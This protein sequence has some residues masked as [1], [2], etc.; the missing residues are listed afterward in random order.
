[1]VFFLRYRSTNNVHLPFRVHAVVDEH[2][3]VVNYKVSVR[4]LFDSKIY[5]QSVVIRIPTPP[6]TSSTMIHVTSGK[7]K[8]VGSENAIVWKYVFFVQLDVFNAYRKKNR[9]HRFQGQQEY[10]ISIKA[11]LTDINTK[12]AWSRP[13]ISLDFQVI[14]F[15]SSG[16]VVRFLK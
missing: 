10:L 9:V 15:T 14:M 5:A 7:A 12:K 8:Y 6:S 13:P 2:A 4:A 1:M 16:L 11:E 3:S